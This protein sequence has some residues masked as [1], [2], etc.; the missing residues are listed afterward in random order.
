MNEAVAIFALALASIGPGQ[1]AGKW[2]AIQ[3]VTKVF[4][5]RNGHPDIKFGV[6]S[7]DR[8]TLYWIECH[9]WKYESDPDFN[10][11]GDFECR[12]TPTYERTTYSTLFTDVVD[13]ARDWESRARFLVPEL[14]GACGAYTD[15]GRSRAFHLRGMS[16][17]IELSEIKIDS[18]L[19]SFT[20]GAGGLASFR[21]TFTV[22]PESDASS[23]IAAPS[24]A[25]WPPAVCG[26]GYRSPAPIK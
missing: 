21:V 9:N 20:R 7:P 6:Q 16:V 12:L 11:S 25:K 10:F 24:A 17:R 4:D 1:S 19:Q 13:S 23:E 8:H 22:E 2:P 15:Y 14:T 18:A 3:S 26:T 5:V